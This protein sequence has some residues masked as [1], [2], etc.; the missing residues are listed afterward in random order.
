MIADWLASSLAATTLTVCRALAV[1]RSN[2]PPTQ[3]WLSH[4]LC[5]V[6]R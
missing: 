5:D 2:C 4:T 3:H 6:A 1:P